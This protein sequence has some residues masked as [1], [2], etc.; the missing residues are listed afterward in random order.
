MH[1]DENE[2]NKY[3]FDASKDRSKYLNKVHQAL[4]RILNQKYKAIAIKIPSRNQ[5]YN[6]IGYQRGQ[7]IEALLAIEIELHNSTITGRS[8]LKPSVTGKID[9]EL[10][11][12]LMRSSD[13]GLAILMI[14]SELFIDA[15]FG[16]TPHPFVQ[17]LIVMSFDPSTNL[18]VS[19]VWA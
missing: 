18:L 5:V 7:S 16:V 15:T 10:Q 13:E 17:C 8:F 2:I 3:L 11:H 19:C 12:F 14:G 4:I 1:K 6:R 9:G